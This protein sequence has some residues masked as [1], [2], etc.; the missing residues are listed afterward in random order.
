MT[1][2]F[3]GPAAGTSPFGAPAS[4]PTDL[5][6]LF[7]APT[8]PPRGGDIPKL[9]EL[10]RYD[11]QLGQLVGPLVLYKVT[12]YET[13][14]QRP[15]NQG[16]VQDRATVD[17]AVLDGPPFGFGGDPA[18]QIPH[19]KTWDPANPPEPGWIKGMYISQ[20]ALAKVML[21]VYAD[22]R[23]G[24]GTGIALGRLGIEKATKVGNN[25]TYVISTNV[26][27]PNDPSK[28][29]RAAFT[30]EDAQIAQ[31]WLAKHPRFVDGL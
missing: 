17:I 14:M 9:R 13:G 1:S 5:R 6:A 12:A 15:G 24:R 26:P 21:A 23:A 16:G 28:L 27:D 8:A 31:A 11:Q 4:A 2:P 30:E 29:L 25:D 19:P 7:G 18:R 10:Y 22:K 20:T 3:G